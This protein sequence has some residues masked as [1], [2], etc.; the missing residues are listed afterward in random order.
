[1]PKSLGLSVLRADYCDCRIPVMEHISGLSR[2]AI[3]HFSH[4]DPIAEPGRIR[5]AFERIVEAFEVD[6]L[7]GG[8]LPADNSPVID[9]DD[10]AARK[11]D[12][13]GAPIVQWGIFWAGAQ[14]D[15]RHFLHVPKPQSVDE[16]LDFRPLDYFPKSVDE[17]RAEFEGTYAAMLASTGESC[18]GI[19]SHYTT[20]F[21]WP[22]AIFGFHLLC[23]AGMDD[24]RFGRLMERFAEVSL[25]IT[26]AWSQVPGLAGFILHDDLTMS[27]G[28][29]FSPA[30]YRRHIFPHYPAIFAPLKQRGIP[31]I[32]CS[33]GDCGMF[34]D[35]IFAAG[36]DGMN[37][38]YLVDMRPLTQRHPDK[39]FIGNINSSVLARGPLD[40]IEREVQRCVES[41]K[42]AR[43][44]V[45]NVGGQ[46]THDISIEH[47]EHYL[48]VRK[49]LCRLARAV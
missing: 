15:G 45:V 47:L 25:R 31:I 42:A 30:W 18:Y 13:H 5:G 10:P 12:A 33:D 4:I 46:L 11:T 39:I 22:L 37:V 28:P 27:S 17:Y 8:G 34:A 26:T 35:D 1:M 38:E 9:W 43:R 16:A 21:H 19:P 3:R 20:A 44:F 2:S 49:K 23:E 36:A 14:E 41:G 6:L 32:F 24:G 7:W 29:I 48:A 40:A